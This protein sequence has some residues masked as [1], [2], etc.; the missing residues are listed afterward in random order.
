[1]DPY[2]I[3]LLSSSSTS[4]TLMTTRSSAR[5]LSGN[6]C[7]SV[8]NTRLP[9]CK[10]TNKEAIQTHRLG[11]VYIAGDGLGFLSYTEIGSRDLSPSL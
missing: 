6:G 7:S 5:M 11:S 9:P 10:Y 1:M 4:V 8:S 3:F 2:S